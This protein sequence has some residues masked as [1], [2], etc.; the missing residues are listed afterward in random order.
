M[1]K[2]QFL[3]SGGFLFLIS[4]LAYIT[5]R[6][7]F[8]KLITDDVGDY[9]LWISGLCF[10]CLL[11]IYLSGY[12]LLKRSLKLHWAFNIVNGLIIAGFGSFGIWGLYTE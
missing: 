2:K 3:F 11:F 7:L 12:E 1:N 8:P 9:F 10:I 6:S 5:G 4:T